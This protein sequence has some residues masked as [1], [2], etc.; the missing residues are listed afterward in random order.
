MVHLSKKVGLA[1]LGVLLASS[2]CAQEIDQDA[3]DVILTVTGALHSEDGDDIARFDLERLREL[4]ETRIETST[5]WTEGTHEFHGTS[6]AAFVEEFDITDGI[7]RARAINDYA[8]DIPVSDAVEGGPI[9][10]WHLD[11][12]PMSLR[13]KG[14]LWVIYPYDSAPEY[15]SEL[16]YSRSIWQLDRIEVIR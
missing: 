3:D 14:P 4:D 7:L 8:I 16:I 12:A 1:A 5:I 2:L 15:R 6:L 11:G 10:A 9:M 13:E